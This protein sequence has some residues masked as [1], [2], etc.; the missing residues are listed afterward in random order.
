MRRPADAARTSGDIVGSS[1]AFRR[2]L[3]SFSTTTDRRSGLPPDP[4]IVRYAK[5]AKAPAQFIPW[6]KAPILHRVA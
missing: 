2:A 1:R 6:P 3:H 5:A 4:E